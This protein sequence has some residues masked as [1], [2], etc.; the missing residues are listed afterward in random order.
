MLKVCCVYA[1]LILIIWLTVKA[2]SI[3]NKVLPALLFDWPDFIRGS[4]AWAHRRSSL[5]VY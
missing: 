1:I 2:A 3:F 5:K 4:V